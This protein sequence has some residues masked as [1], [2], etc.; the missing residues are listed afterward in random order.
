MG[1]GKNENKVVDWSGNGFCRGG[2]VGG[3]QSG[4]TWNRSCVC[5]TIEVKKS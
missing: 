3:N 4:S 2:W 5:I 1:L